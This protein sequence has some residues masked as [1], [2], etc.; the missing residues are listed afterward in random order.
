MTIPEPR[1]YLKNKNSTEPTLIV[2]QAKYNG[3]RVYLSAVEKI[4][5]T[6]WDFDKQRAIITRK[7]LTGADINMWLDKMT[8]EF[9]TI[10]RN[11]LIEE[12]EPTAILLT[13]KLQERLNLT[14]T[15]PVIAE[16]KKTFF[17][18]IEKYI[19]EC[20]AYKSISTIISVAL[21][22]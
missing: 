13:Q 2:M 19:H 4:K 10:F 16:Q 3:Q 20:S 12:I 14:T 6:D 21:L 7:N 11:C 1:F 18:F 8:I 17:L 15:Q 22:S 9:K 5:P